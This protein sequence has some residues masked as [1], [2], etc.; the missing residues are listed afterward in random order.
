MLCKKL[1]SGPYSDIHSGRGR[2]QVT[3]HTTWIPRISTI[4]VNKEPKWEG[5]EGLTA[6]KSIFSAKYMAVVKFYRIV[7]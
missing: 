5:E 6:E 1:V 2:R 4:L 7:K 3:F